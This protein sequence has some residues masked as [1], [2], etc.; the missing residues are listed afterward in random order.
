VPNVTT[1]AKECELQLDQLFKNLPLE[2]EE[3][4][5]EMLEYVHY[6]SDTDPNTKRNN[7]PENTI[8]TRSMTTLKR[9]PEIMQKH[10][11]YINSK[12]REGDFIMDC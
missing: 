10:K 7:L 9:M 11:K 3:V 8:T 4:Y 6:L 2:Y 5:L 12:Q 1:M